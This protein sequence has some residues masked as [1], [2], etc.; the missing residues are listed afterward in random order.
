[1]SRGFEK[2]NRHRKMVGLLIV[3][4]TID[5]AIS[6]SL[7]VADSENGTEFFHRIVYKLMFY[8]LLIYFLLNWSDGVA[9]FAKDM[10]TGFG[11]MMIGASGAEAMEAISDPMDII[12]K[13]VH[14]IAPIY[15]E[16]FKIHGVM[17]LMSK[18]ALWLP[19]LFFAVILTICFFAIAIQMTL[20]YLE[21]Y[22]AMVSNFATFFL[23]GLKFTRKYAANGINGIF[24]VCLTKNNVRDKIFANKKFLSRRMNYARLFIGIYYH[25]SYF[26]ICRR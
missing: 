10:F 9:N 26:C 14:I 25:V 5:L 12:S 11:G 13:G 15:N 4:I 24:A 22:I 6:A 8:V 7:Y 21:F 20:A 18:I 19:S 23:S 2:A 17:D 3:L 16:L 1:M